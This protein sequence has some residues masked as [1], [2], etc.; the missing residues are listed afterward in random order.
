MV[1]VHFALILER[2]GVSYYMMPL[3][4]CKWPLALS[5][6]PSPQQHPTDIRQ[7]SAF[8]GFRRKRP[9]GKSLDDETD[10]DSQP[11]N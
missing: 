11:E 5:L 1:L 3:Q 8:N 4:P 10:I 6:H 7:T 2:P 9:S